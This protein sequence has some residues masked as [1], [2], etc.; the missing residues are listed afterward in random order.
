MQ[1]EG[2]HALL[3]DRHHYALNRNKGID[4]PP[5]LRSD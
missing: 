3:Y 2:I 4:E 5:M 1:F